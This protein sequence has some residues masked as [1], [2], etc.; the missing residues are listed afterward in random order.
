MRLSETRWPQPTG[1]LWCL[2]SGPVRRRTQHLPTPASSGQDVAQSGEELLPELQR[3][4]AAR[5][6]TT[7][8]ADAACAPFASSHGRP[9]DF[10]NWS[11]NKGDTNLFEPVVVVVVVVRTRC[12]ASVSL[13]IRACMHLIKT[14]QCQCTAPFGWTDQ[15]TKALRLFP[16][17]AGSRFPQC[18]PHPTPCRGKR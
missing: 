1:E 13:L 7:S 15:P 14:D 18:K 16:P 6:A 9:L 12:T 3:S 4:T 5:G 11:R 17:K 10:T 8:A 2:S